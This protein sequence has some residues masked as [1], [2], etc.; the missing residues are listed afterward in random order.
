M[1]RAFEQS[2]LFVFQSRVGALDRNCSREVKCRVPIIQIKKIHGLRSCL[3]DVY[4]D[5]WSEI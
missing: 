5:G 2:A 3:S 1:R 4:G